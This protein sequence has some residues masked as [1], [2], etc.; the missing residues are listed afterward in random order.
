MGVRR[1]M[2][3]AA[4]VCSSFLVGEL[5]AAEPDPTMMEP[6]I[7]ADGLVGSGCVAGSTLPKGDWF[8]IVTSINHRGNRIYSIQFDLVCLYEDGDFALRI[9][10]NNPRLRT[11]AVSRGFRVALL[12]MQLQAPDFFV[13][14]DE[15]GPL[16][17]Y[18]RVDSRKRIVAMD[19]VPLSAMYGPGAAAKL[20][21]SGAGN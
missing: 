2:V 16:M 12:D 1:K 6:T 15:L 14:Q 4:A 10:N 17:S 20:I 19:V 8:G 7:A 5:V 9:V 3:A 18:F 21:G 13:A 11:Q